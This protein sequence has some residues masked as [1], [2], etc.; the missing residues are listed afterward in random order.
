MIHEQGIHHCVIMKG[1]MGNEV[2][3][4]LAFRGVE[5]VDLAAPVPSLEEIEKELGP[6]PKG[7]RATCP[8]HSM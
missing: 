3:K 1:H 6:A 2:A 5:V 8:V 4:A 7:G